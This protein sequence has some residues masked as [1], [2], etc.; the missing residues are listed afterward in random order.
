VTRADYGYGTQRVDVTDILQDLF[1]R[2][3]V[4]GP[5]TVDHPTM[6]GD[7]AQGRK[8]SLRIFATNRRNRQ[9]EFDCREGDVLS[10]GMFAPPSDWNNRSIV[11]GFY[12]IQGRGA[13]VTDLLQ[14][15]VRGTGLTVN[16]DSRSLGGDPANGAP[17]LLIVIYKFHGREQAAA[18]PEGNRLSIP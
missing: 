8:K 17:K 10:G 15:M 5:I 6:G 18:V 9:R 4:N 3:G 1:P 11:R 7:P 14:S 2:G 13:N 12:G 16:V